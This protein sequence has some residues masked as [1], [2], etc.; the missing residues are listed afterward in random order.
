[1]KS[2]DA[3]REIAPDRIASDAN[4]AAQAKD[5]N[6]L[7]NGGDDAITRAQWRDR[8]VNG[9]KRARAQEEALRGDKK[10][11]DPKTQEGKDV[12][13]YFELY[14]RPDIQ[15]PDGSVDGE[16][17]QIALDAL[18]SEVG[19]ERWKKLDATVSYNDSAT[20]RE[21]KAD[22]RAYGEFLDNNPKY[23]GVSVEDTR[24]VDR[25]ASRVRAVAATLG[26]T[27]KS[28]IAA[29]IKE[30]GY[31]PALKGLVTQALARGYSPQYEKWRKSEEGQKS[32]RW[33]SN[34]RV[35]DA[36]R[37]A[38]KGVPSDSGGS[39]ST[40][41]TRSSTSARGASGRGASA[42]R[43]ASGRGASSR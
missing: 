25:I 15:N 34:A 43:G 29:V 2:K 33:F 3:G 16:A 35:D 37:Y 20:V 4:K 5:D 14:D 6:L 7:N 24:E 11:P 36:A 18:R 27:Q 39:S 40:S 32:M 22:M 31:D 21:Y 12:Q 28:V 26:Y 41:S 13:K 9:Q 38:G 30:E 42:P 8:Y 19:E 1:M 17:F 23:K 10:Y